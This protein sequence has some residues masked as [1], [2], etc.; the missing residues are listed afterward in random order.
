MAAWSLCLVFDFM[1][2][3]WTTGAGCVKPGMR[4]RIYKFHMEYSL[5]VMNMEMVR[6][7]N[8]MSDKFKVDHICTYVIISSS[9]MKTV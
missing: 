4:N 9:Q 7:F 8:V 3:C 5:Y 6:I 2:K 1:A